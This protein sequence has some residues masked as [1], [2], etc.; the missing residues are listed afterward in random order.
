MKSILTPYGLS[1]SGQEKLQ[2]TSFWGGPKP[3]CSDGLR[4]GTIKSHYFFC[5][6]I[7]PGQ[8]SHS[9]SPNR[10]LSNDLSDVVVRQRKVALH[11]SSHLTP[12]EAWWS[13]DSTTSEGRR[14]SSEVRLG[15]C[16]QIWGVGQIWRAWDSRLRKNST[17][18][19]F[20]LVQTCP[21]LRTIQWP[22]T[23]VSQCNF[24]HFRTLLFF[25]LTSYPGEI[26]Y[27]N[28]PNRQLS[29]GARSW[30]CIEIEMLIPLGAHA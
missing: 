28:S 16:T 4:A 20:W 21:D 5:L 18:H 9:N 1:N 22:C 15:N 30:S 26:A 24:L 11:T 19:L 2:F 7:Y 6:R 13:A 23:P 25:S 10:E 17:S 14:V 12:T 8:I 3:V 29:N 27:F